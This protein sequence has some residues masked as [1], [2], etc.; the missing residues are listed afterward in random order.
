MLL[1]AHCHAPLRRYE[2]ALALA[3]RDTPLDAGQKAND[4]VLW[5]S[6][7]VN[8]ALAYQ[9]RAGAPSNERSISLL[10]ST[11]PI[12]EDRGDVERLGRTMLQLGGLYFGRELGERESNVAHSVKLF[13]STVRLVSL[14]RDVETWISAALGL[15][16][17]LMQLRGG[18]E[19]LHAEKAMLMY[20]A[21]VSAIREGGVED[22]DALSHAQRGYVVAKARFDRQSVI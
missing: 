19:R 18:D 11:L 9:R 22:A 16:D 2:R 17:A 14:D 12:W 8:C 6:I 13:D 3:V 7:A 10:E 4:K 1:V 15:S 21:A 5:A 20:S